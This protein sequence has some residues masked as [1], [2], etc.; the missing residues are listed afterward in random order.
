MV[1][2]C[3][4]LFMLVEGVG[5]TCTALSNWRRESETRKLDEFRL[6]AKD[7]DEGQ[8]RTFICEQKPGQS[9]NVMSLLHNFIFVIT[10]NMLQFLPIS[11]HEKNLSNSHEAW[12]QL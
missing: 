4:Y 9:Y 11:A 7:C 6:W 1:F 10:K 2:I 8:M 5:P 3:F 12:L